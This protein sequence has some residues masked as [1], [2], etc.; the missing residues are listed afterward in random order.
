MTSAKDDRTALPENADLLSPEQKAI[1][2]RV[3]KRFSRHRNDELM[4]TLKDLSLRH[5]L[6]RKS[7]GAR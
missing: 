5:L 3:E 6:R 2:A 1:A 4:A 7:R